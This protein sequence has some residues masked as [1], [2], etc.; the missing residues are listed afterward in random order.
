MHVE[1]IYYI[2]QK[3]ETKD[4]IQFRM[5]GTTYPDRSYKIKRESTAETSCIEYIEEGRGTVHLG[6]RVFYPKGGDSYFLE[7]GYDQYYYSDENTP[8]KKHFIN[9]SGKLVS[10]LAEAY[11]ISGV[12]YF[13]GLDLSFELERII[14]IGREGRPDSTPELIALINQIFLKMHNYVKNSEQ[15]RGI[16]QEMKDYLNTMITSK[17][18]LDLLCREFSHSESQTIRIFK[19]AFGITPYAY[20]MNKKIDFAK[21]LLKNTSLTV[22]EISEKLC[23]ADEYYFSDYFKQKVGISPS[24]FRNNE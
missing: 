20:T 18:R 24:S 3:S 15:P 2:N 16:A 4:L 10:A 7:S 6:E 1:D 17:F 5:C 22:K 14:K 9:I 21:K 8:W 11:G 12:S 13:P 23:F 19:K